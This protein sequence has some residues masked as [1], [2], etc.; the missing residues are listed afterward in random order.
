MPSQEHPPVRILSSF[1]GGPEQ[2][3]VA[4]ESCFSTDRGLQKASTALATRRIGLW[5]PVTAPGWRC[6]PSFSRRALYSIG[7]GALNS[8]RYKRVLVLGWLAVGSAA[9]DWTVVG[10]VKYWHQCKRRAA[11]A[12]RATKLQ[13]AMARPLGVTRFNNL[14][15]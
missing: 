6:A 4:F 2:V 11:P 3:C 12:Q 13:A 9:A 15:T 10:G 1:C 8:S 5:R 7:G 14:I